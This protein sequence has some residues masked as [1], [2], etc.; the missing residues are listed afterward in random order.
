MSGSLAGTQEYMAMEKLHAVRADGEYDLI[1]LDTPPTSNALDFLDGPRR[2]QRFFDGRIFTL[3]TPGENVSF[4]RRAASQLDAA[5]AG[6]D[7]PAQQAQ[8]QRVVAARFSAGNASRS[9]QDV[10][11]AGWVRLGDID[12]GRRMKA[13]VR[14][15]LD[16]GF[17]DLRGT[18]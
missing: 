15:L 18:G 12:E 1:V 9:P 17:S 7:G 3:F 13:E 5:H 8:V 16:K 6:L 4:I 14:T 10:Y 11:Y 2:L